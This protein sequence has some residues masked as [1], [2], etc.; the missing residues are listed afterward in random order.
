MGDTPS[1]AEVVAR[2]LALA[3]VRQVFAY[4]G[5]TVV[6]LL[7]R[8]R[9]QDIDVVLARREATAAV[10]ADWLAMATGGVG[11]CISTLG[12]GSTALANGVASATL[13][14]VPVLALSGQIDSG[15]EQYFTHQV[16]DHGRLYAPITK[17]AGRVEP[18]S[19]A[20][21]MR[22]ALRVAT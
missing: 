2:S 20:T 12:P 17:W 18:S 5:E 7:E 1:T 11:A 22:R 14:R 19:E 15:R 21:T 16:V 4:P 3:G 9:L 10:M 13:D 8:C 6:D